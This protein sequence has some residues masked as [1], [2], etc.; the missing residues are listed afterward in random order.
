MRNPPALRYGDGYSI[1]QLAQQWRKS[2]D[3]VRHLIN[4]G[5]L[6]ADANGVITNT[7]LARFYR[8]SGSLLD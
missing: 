5:E 1:G 4:K 6:R 2:S 3:F 8:E 7:E